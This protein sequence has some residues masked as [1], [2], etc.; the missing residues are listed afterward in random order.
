MKDTPVELEIIRTSHI[1]KRKI[2]EK[3]VMT[4][5]KNM[6]SSQAHLIG[7]IA[8]KGKDNQICQ[9]DIEENFDL[10]RSSVSLMLNNMEKNGLIKRESVDN[11][12]RLKKVVLTE[13][14]VLLDNKI[15]EAIKDINQKTVQGISD[16]ELTQFIKILNKIKSNNK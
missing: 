9:K 4:I 5:D 10:H 16:D 14:A 6:T 13:K 3:I 7:F 1:L 2:E 15:R 11:D 12:G 8:D